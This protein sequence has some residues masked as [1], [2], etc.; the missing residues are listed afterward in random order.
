MVWVSGVA[1]PTATA[2]TARRAGPGGFAV[3]PGEAGATAGAARM[4]EVSAVMLGGMLALQ[5]EDSPVVRDRRARR[6]A[7][8]ILDELARLQRSL[9]GGEAEPGALARLAALAE[10]VPDAADPTPRR[11]GAI[12]RAAGPHR[13]AP[14]GTCRSPPPPDLILHCRLGEAAMRS[15]KPADVSTLGSTL[16]GSRTA[17]RDRTHD[18]HPAPGLP[19]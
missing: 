17:R 6:H 11:A 14:G 19:S 8:A 7:Q 5:E 9:L 10:L 15:Y 12:R 13:A 16:R 3:P 2:R 1:G 18:G 4:E